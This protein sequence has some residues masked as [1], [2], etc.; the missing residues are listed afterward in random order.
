M[1]CNISSHIAISGARIGV[2]V[3][4]LHSTLS[5]HTKLASRSVLDKLSHL[6]STWETSPK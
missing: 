3:S 4:S 1:I 6:S 5:L 2:F